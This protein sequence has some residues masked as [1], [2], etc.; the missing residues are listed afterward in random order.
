MEEI[1]KK[2]EE[3]G[4]NVIDVILKELDKIDPEES[5]RLRLNLAE[6]YFKEAREFIDKG[7]P[8]QASEKLYKV[9]EELIK[10]LAELYDTPEYEEFKKEGRWYTYKL[11]ST[12]LFLS[13]KLGD[14]VRRG[15]DT[16]YILDVWG[17]HEGKLSIDYIKEV[18]RDIEI[19][20]ENTRKL[21]QKN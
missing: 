10:L 7:D 13:K 17:F 9:A 4:I 1:L 3:K 18:I 12:S 20:L 14:W 2:A 5:I 15:W 21:T 8:I 6:K 16:G 19:M 11:Q